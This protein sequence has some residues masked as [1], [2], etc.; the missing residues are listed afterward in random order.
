MGYAG[1]VKVEPSA[2]RMPPLT[3]EELKELRRAL[4]N[5]YRHGPVVSLR[6]IR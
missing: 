4:S 1:K 6:S 2:E 3:A 5:L